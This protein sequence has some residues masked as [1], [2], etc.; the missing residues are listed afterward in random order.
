MGSLQRSKKK[1]DQVWKKAVAHFAVCFI[2]GFF[3]GFTPTDRASMPTITTKPTPPP[4]TTARSVISSNT[5]STSLQFSPHKIATLN[6]S[7]T[8]PNTTRRL[9]SEADPVSNSTAGESISDETKPEDDLAE[10]KQRLIIIITPANGRDRYQMV[11]LRRLA[12]TLKLVPQP[13][14]WVVVEKARPTRSE[15]KELPEMLRMTKVMYRH[16]LYWDHFREEEQELEHQRNL[17]LK[18]LEHHRLNGIVHF[19]GIHH[20]YD[21]DF[22]QELRQ[23]DMLGTWP[24]AL[25]WPHKKSDEVVIQ[26]PFS[27]SSHV[28]DFNLA[29]NSSI[30][31]D[32]ELRG[33]HPSNSQQISKVI[34][35]SIRSFSITNSGFEISHVNFINFLI[36]WCRS[37]WNL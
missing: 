16:I 35:F 23:I 12:Y 26:G 30:L 20:V 28:L 9:T 18:H 21:L 33:H 32:Y 4:T 22:F 8:K 6:P 25:L 7:S 24:M 11:Y 13:L 31:W 14:L 17:G 5:L 37:G 15:M 29:F 27:D 36:F 2:M 34:S 10:S 19:A 1:V 3:T